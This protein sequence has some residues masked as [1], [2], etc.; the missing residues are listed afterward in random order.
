[1]RSVLDVR[2]LPQPDDASCGPTCLHAVYRY[3]G[4]DVPLG[5]LRAAIPELPDGGTLAV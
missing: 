2:P 4:E 5:R 1:M 3:F